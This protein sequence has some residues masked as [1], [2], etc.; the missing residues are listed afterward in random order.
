MAHHK[1]AR[2]TRP[3]TYIPKAKKVSGH[4]GWF[5]KGSFSGSGVT[6]RGG[7]RARRNSVT[8]RAAGRYRRR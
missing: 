2:K 4:T 7:G 6:R 3:T 5:G 1:K 8:G